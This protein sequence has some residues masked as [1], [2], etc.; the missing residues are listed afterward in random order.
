MRE[1]SIAAVA[2]VARLDEADL[3]RILGRA[4]G[5]HLHAL[6]HNREL[7]GGSEGV[8]HSPSG[9]LAEPS[10]RPA[11]DHSRIELRSGLNHALSTFLKNASD[12]R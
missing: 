11:W 3:V 8:A 5:R 2:D 12:A 4:V 6:A 9:D 1:R 10:G 7:V